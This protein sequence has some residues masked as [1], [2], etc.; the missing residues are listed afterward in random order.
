MEKVAKYVKYTGLFA[1]MI[2]G[3]HSVFAEETK[4]APTIDNSML[5]YI[6]LAIT[7]F[8]LILILIVADVIKN[9]SSDKELWKKSWINKNSVLP[10]LFLGM[11]T[12]SNNA[13]ASTWLVGIIHLSSQL[14][15]CMVGFNCVLLFVLLYLL[16]VL[17]DMLKLVRTTPEIE[18]QP[19]LEIWTARMTDAVPLDQEHEILMDHEYDGI[20]ELDNNLPPWWLYMFYACI[21]FAFI[22]IPYYHIGSGESQEEEYNAEM[23][24]AKVQKEAYLAS[25]ANKVNEK[26]V[27]AFTDESKLEAGKTIFKTFCSPCHGQKGEG[28][29]GPNLTDEYW[30]HGGG[31]KN[32]FST[33]KYGVPTKGMIPWETQLTPPQIQEVASYILTLEG[34]NPENPKA[35][36]GKVYVEVIAVDN[37]AFSLDSVGNTK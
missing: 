24:V 17:M 3:S 13:S 31:I 33:I 15:W 19:M 16:K 6:L 28:G 14:F 4:L 10:I 5:F 8:L 34:T 11:L 35:P 2:L 7:V 12:I 21:L 27:T 32:L 9:L 36:E 23:E 26:N 20:R 37:L 18:E 22:Y 25:V 30:I 1:L 29:V